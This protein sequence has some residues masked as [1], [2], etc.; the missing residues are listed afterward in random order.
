VTFLYNNWNDIQRHIIG[1]PVEQ[2]RFGAWTTQRLQAFV[3][4]VYKSG[5]G[6]EPY[7]TLSAQDALDILRLVFNDPM[8]N[9]LT[10]KPKV[11]LA[12]IV[13]NELDP[14]DYKDIDEHVIN[15]MKYPNALDDAKRVLADR[16]K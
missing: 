5:K 10:L 8:K 15:V 14:S 1:A 9:D 6:L 11:V 7:A 4:D 13:L 12:L 2:Q 16:Y 3:D